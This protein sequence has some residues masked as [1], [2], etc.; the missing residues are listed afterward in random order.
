M[1]LDLYVSFIF[2]LNRHFLNTSAEALL[3][4]SCFKIIL[5]QEKATPT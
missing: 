3:F 1:K 5:L 2:F 4:I